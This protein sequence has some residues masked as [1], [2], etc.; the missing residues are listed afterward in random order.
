MA[1]DRSL[2]Q[3]QIADAGT[4]PTGGELLAGSPTAASAA[5]APDA[6]GLP[7]TTRPSASIPIDRVKENH[8]AIGRVFKHTLSAL[9]GK[10][11]DYVPD[12]KTGE[13]TEQPRQ[14]KS[15]EFFRRLVAGVM[16]G[17]AA[18]ESAR[19]ESGFVG[20]FAKGIGGAEQ[21]RDAM[22]DRR[23][24]AAQAQAADPNKNQNNT[25]QAQ[26]A[27]GTINMLQAGHHLGFHTDKELDRYN[28]S[29]EGTKQNFLNNGGE[30]AKITGSD[31]Q[32][33]NGRP[34]NGPELM[35]LYN[36]NQLTIMQAPD[37]YHRVPFITHD[38][39]GLEHKDGKWIDP[40][41][42]Q[43]P[44]WNKHGTVYLVDIPEAMWSQQVTLTKDA[45][46]DVAGPGTV[47][48]SR[49]RG[50][51]TMSTTLGSIHALNVRSISDINN[52]RQERYR[53]P[54][55]KEE[56]QQFVDWAEA[57]NKDPGASPEDKALAAIRGP[58]GEHHLA[59]EA[60]QAGAEEAAKKAGE[61][62]K[63]DDQPAPANL[64]ASFASDIRSSYPD[65]T[66]GQVDSLTKGLGKNPTNKDYRNQQDRA[67]KYSA[68][69]TNRIL[70]QA[71][72]DTNA[73]AK[74]QKP[75]IGLD[76]NG[77]QVF[78]NAGSAKEY[79]LKQVREVGQAEAEKVT[80]AR[81]LMNVFSSIDPDDLGVLQLAKKL[82]DQGKLGPVA[83][84][85]Q[86]FLN[87]GGSVVTFDAGDPEVQ[88]LFTKLGL[89]QTALM[90]VHV[91]SRGGAFLLEHF[92]DL[93]NAKKMS[94]QAFL[95]ALDAE[96]RYVKMKAMLPTMPSNASPQN[97]Q[98]TTT[99]NQSGLSGKAAKYGVAPLGQ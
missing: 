18:G 67:E 27:H 5:P 78:A 81:S 20:G 36:A 17:A 93:A 72:R 77:N 13:L 88:R 87:K 38:T 45:I 33:L 12:P 49:G 34:G 89:S 99:Q 25:A 32:E 63:P 53:A 46:N 8:S 70:A 10:T 71:A 30:L 3:N 64:V 6:G 94:S 82:S 24:A 61:P 83:S 69:N 84:R 31:G 85:L 22:Q 97:G 37:G 29:V 62:V 55:S 74:G 41:T 4:P 80:N 9:E 90:Q 39:L 51:D 75:I 68:A 44:D 86:D 60:Q 43:E 96:N 11:I 52:A 56:A 14:A 76:K 57:V 28:N 2:S 26:I 40:K 66:A 48:T 42:G 95:T 79:G 98:K 47:D 54:K 92:N 91:G 58:I 73:I 21:A 23:R 35:R 1:D 16:A 19:P 65:L 50:S 15:G 7:V 59:R